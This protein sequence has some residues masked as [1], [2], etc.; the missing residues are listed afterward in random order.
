MLAAHFHIECVRCN[1]TLIVTVL[2]WRHQNAIFQLETIIFPFRKSGK[3]AVSRVLSVRP[4]N[5]CSWLLLLYYLV[6]CST[7]FDCSILCIMHIFFH[8]LYRRFYWWFSVF[9]CFTVTNLLQIWHNWWMF[10]CLALM[11]NRGDCAYKAEWTSERHCLCKRW[12]DQLFRNNIYSE[13]KDVMQGLLR[14]AAD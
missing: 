5:V 10:A 1:R 13:I 6:H 12:V 14:G 2:H 8:S 4:L 9:S 11:H 7:W 3:H